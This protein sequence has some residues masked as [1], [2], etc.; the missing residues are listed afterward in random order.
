LNVGGADFYAGTLL[1]SIYGSGAKA[2]IAN[3]EAQKRGHPLFCLPLGSKGFA[4]DIEELHSFFDT[5][6]PQQR[7]MSMDEAM[8]RFAEHRFPCATTP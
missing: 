8:L 5:I 6:P 2:L 7:G 3:E 4:L 1:S